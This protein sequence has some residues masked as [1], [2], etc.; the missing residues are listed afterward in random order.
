MQRE[1]RF[2]MHCCEHKPNFPSV[3]PLVC[4]F[5]YVPDG[6]TDGHQTDDLCLQLDVVS[7][8]IHWIHVLYRL[9]IVASFVAR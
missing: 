8:V 9:V 3:M 5:E 7:I 2:A 4:H 1:G 6:Q